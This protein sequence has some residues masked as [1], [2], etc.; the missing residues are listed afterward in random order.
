VGSSICYPSNLFFDET[1]GEISLELRSYDHYKLTVDHGGPGVFWGHPAAYRV[2]V[3]AQREAGY[4][5]RLRND[6]ES[7]YFAFKT[8]L[9]DKVTLFAGTEFFHFQSNENA[10]WNR[11]TQNLIDNGEYIIGEPINLVDPDFQNTANRDLVSFPLGYGFFNGISNFN[12]LVVPTAVVDAAVADGRI[13]AEA[14]EAMLNLAERDDL[15][16]AYGQPLPSTGNFDPA[17]RGIDAVSETLARLSSNPNQGY[18]YT[19]AYFDQGGVVFTQPISGNQ[20]LSDENDTSRAYNWVTFAD[21][22]WS[23]SPDTHWQNKTLIDGLKTEKLSS[24]GYAIETQQL[25]VA[26]RTEAV[27]DL[28]FGKSASFSYGVGFRY[29]HSEMVQ[30]YFA[31]PFARRDVSRAEVSR[32]SIVLAGPQIGPDGLNYWSPDIGA[33]VASDLFQSSVFS[34]FDY[35]PTEK[36]RIM[37][38]GRAEYALYDVDLPPMFKEQA[39]KSVKV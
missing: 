31:E 7:A 29:T 3:T 9:N 6:F 39:M 36:L 20:I 24:Y 14:R 34:Q 4:Y 23:T 37:L 17:F 38:S 30:D 21:L 1:R 28:D 5:D 2:S 19:Q 25:V 16:R 15:A 33:N 12:A 32:N 11:V 35:Q 10:G 13:S 8:D 26:N 27:S 22:Y 18:R